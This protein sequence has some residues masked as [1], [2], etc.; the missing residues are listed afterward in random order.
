MKILYNISGILMM[1]WY[2]CIRWTWFAD[3]VKYAW[4]YAPINMIT[5]FLSVAFI[6]P[7]L[8]GWVYIKSNNIFKHIFLWLGI[9][10]CL[11]NIYYT[12]ED[13]ADLFT[14]ISNHNHM[15]VLTQI[16][17]IIIDIIMALYAGLYIFKKD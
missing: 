5:A 9:F 16:I 1:I 10:L 6:V 13:M 17:F 15:S 14:A 3:R 4:A 8:F 12:Y 7:T 2:A 11:R